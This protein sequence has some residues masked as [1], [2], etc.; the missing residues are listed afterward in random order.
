VRA[1]RNIFRV[2]DLKNGD[3][4]LIMTESMKI[5]EKEFKQEYKNGMTKVDYLK[6]FSFLL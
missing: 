4:E 1:S 6:K 3:K 5:L 2:S